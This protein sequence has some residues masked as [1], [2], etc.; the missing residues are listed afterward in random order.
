MTS[1]RRLCKFYR[2]TGRS[3]TI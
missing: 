2:K 1:D 3:S